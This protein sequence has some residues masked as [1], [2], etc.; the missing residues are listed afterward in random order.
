MSPEMDSRLLTTLCRISATEKR[1]VVMITF[2]SQSDLWWT[3]VF[4][5]LSFLREHYVLLDFK[6]FRWCVLESGP[7]EVN[8]SFHQLSD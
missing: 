5:Y 2:L 1:M 4:V 3:L 6:Y 7:K 8:E